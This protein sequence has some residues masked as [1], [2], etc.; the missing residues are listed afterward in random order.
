MQIIVKLIVM[1]LKWY[2]AFTLGYAYQNTIGT[3]QACVT[4]NSEV[5]EGL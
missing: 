4:T 3:L 2:N 1:G 5:I